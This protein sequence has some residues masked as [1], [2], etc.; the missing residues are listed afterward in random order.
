[1]ALVWLCGSTLAHPQPHETDRALAVD[2]EQDRFLARLSND[3][4]NDVDDVFRVVDFLL[5]DLDDDV[6]GSEALLQR[7]AVVADLGY[8]DAGHVRG[9]GKA[10]AERISEDRE[11]KV[12]FLDMFNFR[13]TGRYG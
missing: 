6:A 3:V 4:A 1:M 12:E 10:F 11:F 13:T 7:R 8:H 2:R 9:N 5:V